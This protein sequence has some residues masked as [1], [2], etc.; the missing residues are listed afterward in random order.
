MASTG[1]R[2]HTLLRKSV[3]RFKLKNFRLSVLQGMLKEER[4]YKKFSFVYKCF[5]F[6]THCMGK[7]FTK[8]TLRKWYDSTAQI[9]NKTKTEYVH[10]TYGAFKQIRVKY[11]SNSWAEVKLVKFEDTQVYIPVL[12]D[13][14]LSKRYGNYMQ[15][16]K[17]EDRV[18][19]HYKPQK[20]A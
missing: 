16:P 4:N 3:L 13:E 17:E 7:L 9:G 12:Y 5:L 14:Y 10:C 18:P 15:F 20:M 1:N 8:K 2:W 6:I 11:P 19:L